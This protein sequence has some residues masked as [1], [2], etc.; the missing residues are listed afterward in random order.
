MRSPAGLTRRRHGWLN[1]ARRLLVTSQKR[2]LNWIV[3]GK[4][5]GSALIITP[6][7]PVEYGVEYV[8]TTTPEITDLEG[9]ALQMLDSLEG[10]NSL[11][12]TLPEYVSVDFNAPQQLDNGP[13]DVRRSPF[14]TTTYPGFPCASTSATQAEINAGFQGVIAGLKWFFM[15]REA[16]P[17]IYFPS[18]IHVAYSW[19]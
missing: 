2:C 18:R 4:L 8:V 17:H 19:T 9:N 12:F 16:P 7:T 14:V 10:D 5:D 15:E 3:R 13:V 1:T 6:D 11:D